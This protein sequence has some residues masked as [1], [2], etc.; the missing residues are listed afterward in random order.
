MLVDGAQVVLHRRRRCPGSAGGAIEARPDDPANALRRCVDGNG[1]AG[2]RQ[3]AAAAP[4]VE[5]EI[6]AR[7]EGQ[8]LERARLRWAGARAKA[9]GKARAFRN[10]AGLHLAADKIEHAHDIG[11]GKAGALQHA[12]EAVAGAKGCRQV[13]AGPFGRGSKRDDG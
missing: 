5:R 6:E 9:N 2:Q 4:D 3:S 1:V 11:T 13:D 12:R 7:A 8:L 10:R